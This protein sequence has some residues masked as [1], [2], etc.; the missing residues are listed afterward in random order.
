MLSS[1]LIVL[2]ILINGLQSDQFEL[3]HKDDVTKIESSLNVEQN[4]ESTDIIIKLQPDGTKE[5]M[6]DILSRYPKFKLIKQVRPN[7]NVLFRS[8][9]FIYMKKSSEFSRVE[10]L[11]HMVYRITRLVGLAVI[12]IIISVTVV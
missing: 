5:D 11:S 2:V 3:N 6:Q 12:M 9:D 4:P 10:S 1:L 8:L 7:D